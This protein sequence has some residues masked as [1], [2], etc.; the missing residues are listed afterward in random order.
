MNCLKSRKEDI[1]LGLIVMGNHA[2]RDVHISSER[3]ERKVFVP[4]CGNH[5]GGACNNLSLA[6]VVINYLG[7]L[8]SPLCSGDFEKVTTHFIW[9]AMV[10]KYNFL[11]KANL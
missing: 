2:R 1:V 10:Q 11:L 6:R 9:F 7:Q 4:L 3:A 8:Y 5:A